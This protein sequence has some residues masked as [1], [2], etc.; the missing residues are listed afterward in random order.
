[1]MEP[2]NQAGRF[3]TKARCSS[4]MSAIAFAII[5]VEA[6]SPSQNALTLMMFAYE[7]LNP[8]GAPPRRLAT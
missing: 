7:I 4:V 6:S 5:Q 3:R 1:M 2:L 8:P